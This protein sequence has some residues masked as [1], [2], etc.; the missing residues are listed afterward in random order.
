MTR[1]LRIFD[2]M[3]IR[4]KLLHLRVGRFELD[5]EEG[6]EEEAV[7]QIH[8]RDVVDPRLVFPWEVIGTSVPGSNINLIK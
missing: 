1:Q 7:V 8:W 6:T 4:V 2:K 3:Y 5:T